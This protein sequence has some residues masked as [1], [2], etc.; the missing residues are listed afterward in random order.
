MCLGSAGRP[1]HVP[2]FDTV[3]ISHVRLPKPRVNFVHWKVFNGVFTFLLISGPVFFLRVWFPSLK[4]YR[5]LKTQET[6]SHPGPDCS[7]SCGS[8]ERS[9]GKISWSLSTFTTACGGDLPECRKDI[10]LV[11]FTRWKAD[12]HFLHFPAGRS[13]NRWCQCCTWRGAHPG[14]SSRTE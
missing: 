4:F 11:T 6:K 2:A 14:L 12:K 1:V 5:F 9:R 13:G 7:W 8:R 3:P 10:D